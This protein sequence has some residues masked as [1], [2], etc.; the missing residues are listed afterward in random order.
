MPNLNPTLIHTFI[1]LQLSGPSIFL[2]ILATALLCKT[3]IN[4]HPVWYNFCVSWVVFGVSFSLLTLC[5][6]QF[7]FE[8]RKRVCFVQAGLVYA[9]PFLASW[10]SLGL[11][12]QVG[13]QVVCCG[14]H[15]STQSDHAIL[16]AAERIIGSLEFTNQ[17][18][19]P[20]DYSLCPHISLDRLDRRTLRSL[21]VHLATQGIDSTLAQR[22]LLRFEAPH[23]TEGYVRV[24][25]YR[26]NQYNHRRSDHWHAPLPISSGD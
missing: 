2:L 20:E 8:P 15:V 10:C 5:G 13:V 11:V 19:V 14:K 6:E 25:N 24:S 23:C 17:E 21:H 16:P 1:A 9:A 3:R 12:V 7:K 22:D 4:R 18:E 26:F